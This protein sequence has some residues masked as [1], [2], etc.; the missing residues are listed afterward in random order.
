VR[1]RKQH[2]MDRRS[3]RGREQTIMQNA[4]TTPDW[5]PRERFPFT[6]RYVELLGNRIHYVDEG[7]GPVLL[8][9]HGNPTWSYLYRHLIARLADAFRCI[10]PDYPGFGLSRAAAGY[11]FRPATHARVIQAFVDALE[12]DGYVPMVQDWGGPIGLWVAGGHPERVAG[13]V[14]GN[15]WAW[16]VT[17]ERHFELFSL[18]MGGPL[19]RLAIRYGNAFVNLLVPAGIQRNRPDRQTMRAYRGPMADLRSR[20]ATAV[21]PREIRGSAAFLGEVEAR[22]ERLADHP[23]LILW[24]D[25]DFAFRSKER[26]RFEGRFPRHR[27]VVLAGAGHFIQEDAPAEIAEAVRAWHPA[28][29][30]GSV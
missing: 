15:T 26:E 2:A 14:I 25:G 10:A 4:E 30:R 19:G 21:F 23:A 18:A 27:T 3:D 7:S 12:L 22:L 16:P 20:M 8:M 9:L 6:P 28:A 29:S 24:G 17:G 13:V 1:E 5:V 11:D